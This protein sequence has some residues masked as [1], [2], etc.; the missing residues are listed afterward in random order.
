M[1]VPV[2]NSF[3]IGWRQL[4][5]ERLNLGFDRNIDQSDEIFYSVNGGVSWL[6]SPFSGS[7]MVRPIFSTQ[8]DTSLGLIEPETESIQILIFPNPVR[9]EVFIKNAGESLNEKLL[10]D[11]AGRVLM[12]TMEDSFDLQTLDSGIYFISVPQ[13]SEKRYKVIKL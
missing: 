13:R 11:A 2:G 6:V 7:A 1:K 10:L 8:M 9:D 4:D 3:F 5:P 12:S